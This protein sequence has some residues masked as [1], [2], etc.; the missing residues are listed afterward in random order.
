MPMPR[1]ASAATR[2]TQR[3]SKPAP[4][5]APRLG[6]TLLRLR[7]SRALTLDALAGRSGI[8]KSM[9]SQIERDRTNP[10]VAT[11]W[12]IARALDVGI[13]AFLSP[14]GRPEAVNVLPG[15]GTPA[16]ASAD[17]R[18]HWKI[19]GPVGLAG[20]FEWY[21]VRAEP[22]SLAASEAHE[23]GTTEHVTVLDGELVVESGEQVARVSTGE[24]ARYRAD[25]R[26]SIRNESEAAAVALVVV[27]RVG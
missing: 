16:F 17:G 4:A 9:L 20:R 25:V 14:R 19:L 10:T 5:A 24:T 27:T 13:D 23:A 18:M 21:E 2:S 1:T 12:R 7:R 8:S 22:R 3:T 6:A 15:Y 11:L 26:H